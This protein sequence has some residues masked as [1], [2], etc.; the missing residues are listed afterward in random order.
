[1]RPTKKFLP[2]TA[3][4]VAGA[5]VEHAD[6][7]AADR[8]GQLEAGVDRHLLA[9]EQ[10]DLAAEEREHVGAVDRDAAGR[11]RSGAGEAE[12]AGALRGRTARFSGNSTEKRDRLICRA[13]TSV[14]P[15][16]VLTVAVSFRLGVML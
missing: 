14:S 7:G 2:S 5:D 4:Q 12:D 1:M 15:K 10:A 13:S 11:L 8:A 3:G 9:A 6:V 16:S